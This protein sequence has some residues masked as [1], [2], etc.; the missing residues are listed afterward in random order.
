MSGSTAYIPPHLRAQASQPNITQNSQ[1]QNRQTHFAQN[2]TNQGQNNQRNK[3]NVNISR[4]R[5]LP[6]QLNQVADS[7]IEERFAKNEETFD[8]SV[9]DGAEVTVHTNGAEID[10]IQQF[11]GCGIRNEILLSVAEIGFKLPTSVQKYAIP[12]I[13]SHHDVIVTSQTGS[14]KTAA[15]MLPVISQILSF[16][17]YR[18]PSV[19]VLVPTR[20]LALQIQTETNKF[21]NGTG[22]KTVC[23][24]G[25]A[26]I[27][28]QLRLLRYSCDILIA[29]PGRLIDI[30]QRGQLHLCAVQHLILDEADRMLDMGFEPQIDK[31]IN[32]FD[33]PTPD[34]RQTLLFSA[35]FPTEVQNL[36]RK[37]MRPDVTRI[38]VGMQDA[39]S[40]IEQ[41]FLYVP[42]TS[43]LSALLDVIGEVD[44]QTL[45]FAERKV[46]VD[47]I[48]EFL[49]DE[50][51]HVVA[52]H[53]DRDMQDRRAALRGFINGRAKIMIAT[54]VAARGIDIPDVAHVINLDLP[55]D[56]DSYIH[57]I[58][59]TGRAGKRGI[60]TSFWNETNSSFLMTLIAHFRQNRQPIPEGLEEF[61]RENRKSSGGG[62]SRGHG[63]RGN[64]GRGNF[65]R[66]HSFNNV[67]YRY[68]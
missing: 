10:P 25:G 6:M 44:G 53:G 4:S 21:T 32:G 37:F 9:Y 68:Y 62:G 19:V 34:Q 12:Y 29:T 41:R 7:V 18:D 55:N 17:R 48:E 23:V 46:K 39:P 33:M 8:M 61:D 42:E 20:E 57:R 52:I 56:V 28:D 5:S 35:T 63:G 67:N 31:V 59:R 24:F 15:Y 64:R 16:Q 66:D 2:P 65:P 51:C 43:K 47:H 22:L 3:N 50:G 60:A 38:E 11:P 49:Y 27:N 30:M 40:L 45:V 26:S 14:G 1:Q 54:D 36:A 13:L 58:G